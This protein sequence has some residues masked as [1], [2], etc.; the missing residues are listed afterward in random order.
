MLTCKSCID[1]YTHKWKITVS[2]KENVK[3]HTHYT[4]YNKVEQTPASVR[5]NYTRKVQQYD[6]ATQFTYSTD[7]HTTG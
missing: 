6:F 2:T 7:Q 1:S 5:D 4:H 3:T